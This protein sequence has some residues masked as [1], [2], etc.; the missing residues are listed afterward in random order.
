[1]WLHDGA[2]FL[3][4]DDSAVCLSK[5]RV[6]RMI[7]LSLPIACKKLIKLFVEKDTLQACTHPLHA[8]DKPL[9]RYDIKS[10][11]TESRFQRNL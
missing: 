7:Q 3:L 8:A 9:L 11:R 10:T 4:F 5:K 1:M 6:G 2:N